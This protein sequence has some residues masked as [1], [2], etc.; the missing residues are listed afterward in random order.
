VHD[1]GARVI[2]FRQVVQ[3]VAQVDIAA[4]DQRYH[5]RKAKAMLQRPVQDRR[6]HGRRLGNEGGLA[7]LGAGVGGTGVQARKRRYQTD[8]TGAEDAQ[9][10]GARSAHDLLAD[11]VADR[12]E[13]DC[14]ARAARA[15]VGDQGRHGFRRRADDGQ[16]RHARQGREAWIAGNAAQL[17][18]F[19]IDRPD[20]AG[21]AAFRHI[22]HHLGAHA[23][24]PQRGAEDGHRA[25]LE[26]AVHIPD[27]HGGAPLPA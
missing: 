16:V 17:L 23:V 9:Q 13:D 24:G 27:A 6:H 8:A 3:H 25:G 5:A 12:R 18:V 14:A 21:E 10:V 26:Q 15:Q 7:R 20:G 19:R 22:V 4:L 2:I 1:D 11:G